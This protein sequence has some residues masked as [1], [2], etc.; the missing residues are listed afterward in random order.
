MERPL[1]ETRELVSHGRAIQIIWLHG[2]IFFGSVNNLL[3]HVKG[4]VEA[5]G[6]RACRMVILDFHE[7]LGIDSSA[8]MVLVRLRQFAEREDILICLSGLREGIENLLR[9][10][11]L[12]REDDK[13]CLVF[14][15]HDAALEWCEDHLLEER[16]TPEE[17]KRSA[18]EWLAREMGGQTVFRQFSSYLEMVSYCANDVL[19]A[20]D[21]PAEFLCLVYSGRVSIVFRTLEGHSLR[22][23]SIRHH[24]LV[25][26]MGLYRTV[27]RGAS[28]LV[29]RPTVVYRLSRQALEQMES[30]SPHLAIAFHKF[31]VRTLAER[32]QFANRE[33]AAL[34]K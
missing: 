28:V 16:L 23:R 8:V 27:P 19:F 13:T 24:T 26:E 22:L 25:G 3:R 14:P 20:Q 5:Q 12:L 34:Q 17:A 21:D 31:E 11:G 32:L 2:F 9:S 29:D 10:G 4:I 7:V 33:V 30:D 15:T 6:P 18:D 1:T